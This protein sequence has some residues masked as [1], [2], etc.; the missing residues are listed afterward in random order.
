[1]SKDTDTIDRV[2]FEMYGIAKDHGFHLGETIGDV[3][4]ERMAVYVA[5]LHGEVSELWEA[6]RRGKLWEPCDK[7]CGLTCE[8]E[9][10]ADIAIRVMDTA[11][12]RGISLGKAIEAKAA[13][14]RTR[15]HKHGKR[16]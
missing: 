16:C 1:M 10:L 14:N 12:A 7:P 4:D 15:P 3:N 6:T 8:E 5:N 13:Y 2:A 11:V 9:E